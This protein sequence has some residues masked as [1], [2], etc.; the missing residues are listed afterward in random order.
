MEAAVTN[1]LSPGERVMCVSI[2]NF[3]ER[4]AKIA[5]AFGTDLVKVN[6]DPGTAA[7]PDEI[8]R[9]L[10]A[11]RGIT[12]VIVTHNETSTGVT[13]PLESIASVVK[14]RDKLLIREQLVVRNGR[15]RCQKSKLEV[16]RTRSHRPCRLS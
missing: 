16:S 7:D 10:D 13:N 15:D 4:F 8:A 2:G 6:F 9:R 1:F 5:Q 12:T 14:A 11:D 3:G